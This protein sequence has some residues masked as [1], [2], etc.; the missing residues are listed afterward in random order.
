MPDYLVKQCNV[1]FLVVEYW[2]QERGLASQLWAFS[3]LKEALD[4][5]PQLFNKPTTNKEG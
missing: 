4:Y 5:M 3:T 2:G 1:G